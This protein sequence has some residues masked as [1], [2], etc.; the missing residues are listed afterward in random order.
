MSNALAIASV[1]AILK[2][3]LN[4]AMIDHDVASTLGPVDVSVGPP[5]LV[6][7]K[8]G[9]EPTQINLF[10]YHVSQ[11][12]A[13]RNAAL[14]SRDS[15]GQR[16]SNAPLAL[17]LHY[18]VSAYGGAEFHAEILLGYAMQLLHETPFMTRDAIRK[19]MEAPSPVTGS[20]LPGPFQTL[21]P[22]GLADQ[23]EQIRIIP[24]SLNTEEMSRLWS[25]MQANYRTTAA[26]QVSVVL[27]ES[28]KVAKAALPVATRNLLVKPMLRPTV[29]AVEPQIAESG[30]T[31]ALRGASLAGE[32]TRVDFGTGLVT[33]SSV[34]DREIKV[35]V[36]VLLTP[37]VKT[38]Q[39]KHMVA[40][41]TPSDPHRGVD[42][43]VCAFVLAPRIDV[44]SPPPSPTFTVARGATL[45]VPVVPG[46]GRA[47]DVLVIVGEK[48]LAV[49][50]RDPLGPATTAS[51]DVAIPAGFSTGTF[52]LRLR[53][54]GADSLLFFDTVAGQYIGPTVNVT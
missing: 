48:A 35:D 31:L 12:A 13:W 22:A 41:G 51:I 11:N 9:K 23:F 49:P 8:N 24:Q 30:K 37:G 17:D 7:Q 16:V 50:P 46:V 34:A 15:T 25:A 5:D 20:I 53:V 28:N 40:F 38:L 47:Q 14:P 2:D 21:P 43:N 36:P 33:P 6:K 39:V 45:T 27:I 10:L 54:D 29:E 4:N 26:Y 19:T 32:I 44:A 52:L 3:L 18:L 1:S 42:S